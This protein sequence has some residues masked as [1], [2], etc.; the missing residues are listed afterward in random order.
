MTK[1]KECGTK[2]PFALTIDG[3]SIF[4]QFKSQVVTTG[5]RGFMAGFVAYNVGKNDTTFCRGRV[6]R[7]SFLH[8]IK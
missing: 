4:I 1:S 5:N 7:I 3:D 2:A 6:S 8:L